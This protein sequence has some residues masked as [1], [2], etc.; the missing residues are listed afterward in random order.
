MAVTMKNSVFWD[1]TPCG[2]CTHGVTSQKTPFFR[3]N[4]LLI[5]RKINALKRIKGI[6]YV[7][8]YF[9]VNILY[10]QAGP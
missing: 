8:L 4:I 3:L 9:M 2:S 7:Y 6:Y 5:S 10:G 1:V